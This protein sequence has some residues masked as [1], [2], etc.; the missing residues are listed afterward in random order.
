MGHVQLRQAAKGGISLLIHRMYAN[1]GRLDRQTLEL[2]SG[3]NIIEAPNESG[4]STWCAFLTAM[5]YGVNSRERDRNGF[6]AEK[7]RC[8]PWNGSAV[9]GRLDCH[10]GGQELTLLRGTRRSGAPMGAFRA[11]YADT[12]DEVPGLTGEHCGEQLLGVSR[13]VFERSA[14]IRQAGLPIQQDAELERRIAA[15]I[16]SGE[17]DTSY[18]E[19]AQQLRRQLNRRQHNKTG[20]IPAL[21]E[22]LSDL[23]SRQAEA[24]RLNQQVAALRSKERQLKEQEQ[25]L[26]GQLAQYAR[27][28]AAQRQAALERCRGEAQA[29]AQR[30]E[31]LKSSL[32]AEQIPENETIGRLRGAIVNLETVRKSVSQAREERDEAAKALLRAEAAAQEGPFAGLTAERAQAEAAAPPSVTPPLFPALAVLLLAVGLGAAAGC[33]L[34]RFGNPHSGWKALLPWTAFAGFFGIGLLLFRLMRRKAKAA[35]QTAALIKRFGTADPQAIQAQAAQYCAALQARDAAQRAADLKAASADALSR[36][37][38]SNEQGILLEV[39]RFAPTAFDIPTADL[40]LRRCAARRKELAEAERAS[41]EA[42]LHCRLLEQQAPPAAAP[43]AA[44]AGDTLPVPQDRE[45]LDQSLAQVRTELEQV[46]AQAE[47]LSGQLALLGDPLEL[48]AREEQLTSQLQQVRQEYD[49]LLRASRALDRANTALQ[50]RFSP[51]L[52][53]RTAEIFAQLTGGRYKSVVLDRSFHF[54]AE[55]AGDPTYRDIQ[56]LS[57]GASDQLYLA[58]RLAICELVLPQERGIPLILDDALASFD[59]ARTEA[60]L[61][62]LRKEAAARQILLFTCHEREARFFAG[63]PEVR[64]QRLGCTVS[65]ISEC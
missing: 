8:I 16:T 59:Q 12:G 3:L 45:P 41:Q 57:A 50:S 51:A 40:L 20:Q 26:C 31:A 17:E 53:K 52:G 62:W 38:T 44:E 1:F 43:E 2:G 36:T 61:S 42:A 14:M 21:E 24:D 55:P 5:L 4:K 25:A 6:I 58:A 23:K 47:R 11:L 34:F 30:A 29:A 22:Q 15:L 13:E 63:D 60:A 65:A 18:S 56:L 37:L 46:R 28:E 49:A 64:V 48:A 9:Q 35:A 19:A 7:N 32:T 10:C 54:S 33:L 39:R 27:R